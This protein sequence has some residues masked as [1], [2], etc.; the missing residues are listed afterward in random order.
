MFGKN[1]IEFTNNDL[2]ATELKAT[3]LRHGKYGETKEDKM[4]NKMPSCKNVW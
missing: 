1:D 2:K 3:E 4:S